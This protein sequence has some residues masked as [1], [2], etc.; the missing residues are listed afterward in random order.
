[1]AGKP[2]SP[3]GRR[4][5]FGPKQPPQP[6]ATAPAPMVVVAEPP[7]VAPPLAF[8]EPTPP[9]PTKAPPN[10]FDA[11]SDVLE[12]NGLALSSGHGEVLV[13][14]EGP[15]GEEPAEQSSP[16]D[17]SLSA[18]ADM[19]EDLRSLEALAREYLREQ[20]TEP[21]EFPRGAGG[22]LSMTSPFTEQAVLVDRSPRPEP[23]KP[24]RRG[25]MRAKVIA[26]GTL[27]ATGYTFDGEYRTSWAK[28]DVG[29]FPKASV[30]GIY[31]EA[32]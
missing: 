17:T 5:V 9:E 23:P 2:K 11:V 32:L 24:C 6:V 18:P 3:K 13:V 15:A 16:T 10:V 21:P 27:H 19:P 4:E 31:L 8:T 29:E 7:V 12:A 1:M 30:D 14:A 25:H 20:P 22:G 26:H 28:G